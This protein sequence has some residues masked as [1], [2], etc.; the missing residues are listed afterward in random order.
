M[1]ENS[2]TFFH[3]SPHIQH[4]RSHFVAHPYV[5]MRGRGAKIQ[6]AVCQMFCR[7]RERAK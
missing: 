3:L 7:V 6:H 2:A 1:M 5:L 4:A